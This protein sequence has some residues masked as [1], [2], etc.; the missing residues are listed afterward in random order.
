MNLLGLFHHKE[1]EDRIKALEE[2]VRQERGVLAVNILNFER[3]DN[4]LDILVKQHLALLNRG[5]K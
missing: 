5:S 3:G 4:A 1:R 2:E